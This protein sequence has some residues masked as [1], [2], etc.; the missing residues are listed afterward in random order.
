MD[1]PV[2]GPSET[3]AGKA[4]AVHDGSRAEQRE[5][6]SRQ[7]KIWDAGAWNRPFQTAGGADAP[8]V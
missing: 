3:K 4:L 1:D 6:D 8:G 7:P 2:D 5:V